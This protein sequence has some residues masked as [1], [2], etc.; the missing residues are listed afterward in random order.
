MDE[1]CGISIGGR[2]E[3]GAREVLQKSVQ[4]ISHF[5]QQMVKKSILSLISINFSTGRG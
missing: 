4:N 1:P 3:K 5:S 2:S